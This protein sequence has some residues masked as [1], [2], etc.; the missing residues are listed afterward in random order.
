MENMNAEN[1]M[2]NEGTETPNEIVVSQEKNSAV[3]VQNQNL[4]SAK[5]LEVKYL[6]SLDM[7]TYKNKALVFNAV[8]APDYQLIDFIGQ[9][10][11]VEHLY[12]QSEEFTEEGTGEMTEGTRIILFTPQGE[13]YSCVSGGVRRALS[14]LF[15]RF[16]VPPYTPPLV[17][18]PQLVKSKDNAMR[19]ILKLKVA[20]D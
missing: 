19:K 12:A 8:S 9:K 4:F 6:T 1:V 13:S 11:A 14:T 3:A 16:G 2:V 5:E 10:I 17:L 20:I 18:I 15:A 7:T